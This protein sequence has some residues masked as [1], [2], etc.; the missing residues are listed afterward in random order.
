MTIAE[1]IEGELAL[2]GTPE[3][4]AEIFGDRVEWVSLTT[5]QYAFRY[6]SADHF[7][8]WFRDHYGPIAR[9][10]GT[11]SA[12]DE[13]RFAADLAQVAHQFNRAEDGTVVAPADYL[14]AVGIVKA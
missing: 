11:L 6:H 8:Q 5:R 10:A 3:H 4:L 13:A 2:W 1:G 12:A 7:S 9:L 14:E